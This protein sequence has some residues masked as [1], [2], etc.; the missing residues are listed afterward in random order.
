MAE[1]QAVPDPRHPEAPR[2]PGL[3]L[4]VDDFNEIVPY[5]GNSRWF[6]RDN[7]F[8]VVSRSRGASTTMRCASD[9][10]PAHWILRN[11]IAGPTIGQHNHS[12]T[13]WVLNRNT[14]FQEL[15]RRASE[16]S[17]PLNAIYE[18]EAAR[19]PDAA[20]HLL[21]ESVLP[22][23][24]KW[25]RNSQPAQPRTL[26]EYAVAL[27]GHR[28]LS[29]ALFATVSVAEGKAVILVMRG[30]ERCIAD[31]EVLVIDGTFLTVP[32][33][34][35][36]CQILTVHS[37][38]AG[39]N[40][41]PVVV[42]MQN[43]RRP[44]YEAVFRR[45]WQA[46]GNPRPQQI[47]TDYEQALRS[48]LA[49]VT[50]IATQGCM[51]HYVQAL[52][53]QARQLG[54]QAQQRQSAAHRLVSLYS[55]LAL[56]PAPQVA[57]GLAELSHIAQQERLPYNEDFHNYFVAQWM[58]RVGPEGFSVHGTAHRTSNVAESFHASLRRALGASPNVWRFTDV[59]TQKFAV[60]ASRLEAYRRGE[61]LA[62][63]NR[64]RL[65]IRT[66]VLRN[67]TRALEQGV[68]SIREFLVQTSRLLD[69]GV[70][71]VVDN[72]PEFA[73]EVVI[74]DNI[75]Q[76]APEVVQA[77]IL[78]PADVLPASPPRVSPPPR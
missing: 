41:H 53:R 20:S 75:E 33:G 26:E 5:K 7:H 23:M 15:K 36:I 34:L 43:R 14:M 31:S 77:P 70:E 4:V 27:S 6:S 44:L 28:L 55:A 63:R 68:I 71:A 49:S 61:P 78:E 73:Q 22:S 76:V 35:S 59:L 17:I 46:A 32:A 2:P 8:Y 38:I 1:Q 66:T 39:H 50:G 29:P 47:I 19:Y 12:P 40:F 58:A 25:R 54:L 42:L 16:E 64:E 51:F 21:Y 69:V 72:V 30:F 18:E 13:P 10:C 74:A 67:N 48:A 56:L 24:R 62:R 52:V 60:S 37:I 3:P 45:I 65:Y 9:R 11:G 57:A